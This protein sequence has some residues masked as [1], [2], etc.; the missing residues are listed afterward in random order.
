MKA[1]QHAEIDMN[2][3][4]NGNWKLFTLS[5]TFPWPLCNSLTFSGE[6]SP[7]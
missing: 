5:Q 7:W 2:V 3:S 1:Q 4:V 6:W